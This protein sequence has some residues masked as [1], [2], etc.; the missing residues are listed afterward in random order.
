VDFI[1]RYVFPGSCCPSLSAMQEAIRNS[2]DLK[3]SHLEDL[4]PHYATTLR[5][6]RETFNA[7]LGE[8]RALGFPESFVRLWEYY[9]C[10]CE[11]GFAERYIGDVHMLLRRPLNRDEPILPPL[12]KPEASS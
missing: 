1:Q 10:Y 8:V 6:W 9:L 4:T 11:A 3:V 5:R 12:P 2:S 7:R